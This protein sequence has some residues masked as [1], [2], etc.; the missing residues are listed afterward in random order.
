[1][2]LGIWDFG[3]NSSHKTPNYLCVDWAIEEGVDFSI[4]ESLEIFAVRFPINLGSIPK[5][6]V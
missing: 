4:C 1:M 5:L 6:R 3:W 2:T